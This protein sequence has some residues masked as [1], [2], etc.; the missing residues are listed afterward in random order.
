MI[1]MAGDVG[2][3]D[4][5]YLLP[6]LRRE[7]ADSTICALGIEQPPEWS[8]PPGAHRWCASR[9]GVARG[10]VLER[11]WL[12]SVRE[13]GAQAL[14]AALFPERVGGWQGKFVQILGASG[15]KTLPDMLTRRTVV[16]SGAGRWE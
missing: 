10:R 2:V 3:R 11:P 1:L 15:A 4:G 13:L 9:A 12:G 5:F 7:V 16:I 14:E 6:V 8:G